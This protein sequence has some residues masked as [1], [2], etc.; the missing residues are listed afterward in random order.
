MNILLVKD[1]TI[2]LD[3]GGSVEFLNSICSTI[4][5]QYYKNDLKI[6]LPSSFINFQKEKFILEDKLSGINR[7]NTLYVTNRKY[8]NNYFY[9]VTLAST[10][11]YM[12]VSFFGWEHYTNL[13]LENGLFYF[14]VTML[15]LLIDSSTRHHESTGCIYDFLRNKTD[16]DICMKRG[17]ICENHLNKIQN[18]IKK[19]ENLSKIY[20]DLTKIFNLLSNASRW[21]KNVLNIDQQKSLIKLDWS[22]FEDDVAN[23]YRKLGA[24]VKQNINLSGFQI[25][26]Y[27][28][29]E[30]TSKQKIRSA[31][32][33]KFFE[34]KVG[35]RVINDYFRIIKTLKDLNLIDKGIIVSYSGFS[36]EASVVSATT[37]IELLHY[38]DLKHRA[39]IQIESKA[40]KY[41]KPVEILK[42]KELKIE[43]KKEHIPPIFVAM[44]FIPELDDVYHLGIRETVKKLDCSCARLDELEFVGGILD[45]IYDSIAS[46]KI[47]IAEVSDPNP[48]V[49]YEIGYAHA[50]KKHVIL[51]T[52]DVSTSPFD[53]R[54]LNPIIYKNIRDLRSKLYN[55]LKALIESEII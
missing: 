52:K 32:D 18:K 34:K 46:S 38:E 2:D 39:G 26:I 50:L 44:P 19:T 22:K 5:F 49:Y 48:N 20:V 30:T 53:I 21:N 37:G 45:K 9:Y 33:C 42:K 16:V 24:N 14:I 1:E 17:Y 36:K 47:I 23:L 31:I 25:D 54:S 13:P 12:I 43:E 3:L 10:N 51:T 11:N 6:D 40:I 8:G 41:E 28:E 27:V 29:E 55:R 35:N 4:N 15:A 7:D